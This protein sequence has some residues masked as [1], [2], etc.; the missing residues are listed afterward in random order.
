MELIEVNKGNCIGV[1]RVGGLKT[2]IEI[3]IAH[4]NDVIRTF[5]CRIFTQ[6]SS[7][8]TKVQEFGYKMGCINFAPQV[9]REKSIRA[10]GKMLGCL[11]A[12][13]SGGNFAAKI[14][15]IVEF[16]ALAKLSQWIQYCCQNQMS[17][18]LI[19]EGV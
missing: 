1:C 3:I 12:F 11:E 19:G 4:K 17:A 9:E 13:V 7:G 16:D 6:M 15:F 8:N 5:A 14:D 2:L 18:A 10:R